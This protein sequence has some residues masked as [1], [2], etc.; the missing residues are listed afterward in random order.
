MLWQVNSIYL[1]CEVTFTI[2]FSHHFY[3]YEVCSTGEYCVCYQNELADHCVLFKY[4][5]YDSRL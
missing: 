2:C 4:V 5:V 1:I 3:A